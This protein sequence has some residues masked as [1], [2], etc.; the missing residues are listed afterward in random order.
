[1]TD[2]PPELSVHDFGKLALIHL[3]LCTCRF[4]RNET[5]LPSREND[6]SHLIAIN[7]GRIFCLVR[8]VAAMHSVMHN[9]QN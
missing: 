2:W 3:Q 9:M 1:M 4:L 6:P 5:G 7:C 8:L